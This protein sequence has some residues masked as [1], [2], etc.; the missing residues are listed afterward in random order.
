MDIEILKE[1]IA[2]QMTEAKKKLSTEKIVEREGRSGVKRFIEHPNILAITG[3]R[4]SGKSVFSL[5]LSQSTGNFAYVNFDD[6]RLIGASADDLNRIL[7]AIYELYGAVDV[8]ALDEIQNIE[9]WELFAS[10][11]RQT[12]KLIITGSNSKLMA[13]ELA[14][15]LTG[16]HIDFTLYPFSFRERL[17]FSPGLYGTE[18]AAKL[19][20]AFNEYCTGS[21]FPEYMKFGPEIVMGIYE[22]IINK[23]CL[24]RHEIRNERSFR[25]LAKYLVSN[26]SKEFTY[27]RLSGILGIKDVHTTK[28]YV[29]YL[30]EAFVIKTIERFSPKLKQQFKAPKKAYAI[31]HG[32]CNFMGFRISADKGRLYENIACIELLRRKS[33]NRALEIY[34]WKN[35]AQNEVDFVVKEGHAV[36]QLIQVCYDISDPSTMKREVKALALASKELRCNNL[37]ILT[38]SAK[39]EERVGNKRVKIVPLWK[40][41]L[42]P[43]ATTMIS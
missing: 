30:E 6:E 4:R 43:L 13:G 22:D 38:G 26:C 32:F 42:E 11:L 5:L 31:D 3:V 21:G 15:R 40:W 14:D 34:Y 33:A 7:Q 36:K 28:N 12:K 35:H 23:D 24:R 10:R 27:S 1:L 37:L 8:I 19:R 17:G 25:E 18:E 16:R 41:M 9:G 39:G 20:R 29:S 2:D